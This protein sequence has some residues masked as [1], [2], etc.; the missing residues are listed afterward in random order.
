MIVRG[1]FHDRE[2]KVTQVRQQI[3]SHRH[4]RTITY[5]SVANILAF[6][7]RVPQKVPHPRGARY[8]RQGPCQNVASKKQ[9][10]IDEHRSS[11]YTNSTNVAK[12]VEQLMFGRFVVHPAPAHD[13]MTLLTLPCWLKRSSW[14]ELKGGA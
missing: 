8:T 3:T 2:G 6:P 4:S 11:F 10:F 7:L 5:E 1:T 14:A 9:K 13:H 12:C